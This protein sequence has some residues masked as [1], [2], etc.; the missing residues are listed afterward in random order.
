VSSICSKAHLSIS[1]S[2]V[3]LKARSSR[4]SVGRNSKHLKSGSRNVPNQWCALSESLKNDL[5]IKAMN[6]SFKLE[7]TGVSPGNGWARLCFVIGQNGKIDGWLRIELNLRNSFGLLSL[8][9]P[10][11]AEKFFSEGKC[12]YPIF[13][14]MHL[15]NV[16]DKCFIRQTRHLRSDV[17]IFEGCEFQNKV[18]A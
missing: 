3:V 6:S 13:S 10:F 5:S 12:Y 16:F 4:V 15:Q 11:Y 7:I 17:I 2:N 1:C 8:I 14:A 18:F 9:W